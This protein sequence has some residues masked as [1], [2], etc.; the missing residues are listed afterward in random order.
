MGSGKTL[1]VRAIAHGCNA[2]I[3]DLSPSTIENKATDKNAI[4][5]IFNMGFTVAREF[6]PSII[7][8]DEIE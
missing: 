7:V 4:A 6:Q 8:M 5:K 1:A 2:I 3:I